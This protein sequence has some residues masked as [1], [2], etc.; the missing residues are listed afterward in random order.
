M[1]SNLVSNL[2]YSLDNASLYRLSLGFLLRTKFKPFIIN[3][4]YSIE[5]TSNAVRN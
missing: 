1:G 5:I 3:I 4:Y 2:R